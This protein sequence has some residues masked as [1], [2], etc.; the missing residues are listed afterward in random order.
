ML[1]RQNMS[2]AVLCMEIVIANSK[3]KLIKS[4][5]Y[6]INFI[7]AGIDEK[8][9][10]CERHGTRYTATAKLC[11]ADFISTHE[12]SSEYMASV[13]KHVEHIALRYPFIMEVE[14]LKFFLSLRTHPTTA[15]DVFPEAFIFR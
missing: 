12:A 4:A 14:K 10:Q 3:I 15:V 11:L 8:W 7:S 2:S 5:E 6:R 9:P 1:G 13:N